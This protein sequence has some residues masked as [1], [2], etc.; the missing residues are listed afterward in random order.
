MNIVKLC[1]GVKSVDDLR[2]HISGIRQEQGSENADILI[3]T[4]MT[5]SRAGEIVGTGSLYW[6][7]KNVISARQEI[8]DIR[9][10]VDG[11][12]KRRCQIVLAPDVIDV[13][14]RRR[15]AFQGWRYLEDSEAPKDLSPDVA[16]DLAAMPEDMKKELIRLGLL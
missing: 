5:P 3:E 16:N 6:V 7:I 4:R 9:P 12:G 8:K 10:I 2:A 11:N 15:A 14:P 13:E 1:V